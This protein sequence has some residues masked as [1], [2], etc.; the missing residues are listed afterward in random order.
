MKPDNADQPKE[1][2]LNE[3][4][5]DSVVD[6]NVATHSKGS[7]LGKLLSSGKLSDKVEIEEI[8]YDDTAEKD[9][10]SDITVIEKVIK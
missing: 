5:N 1:P 2:E 6:E 7:L 10:L 3:V 9:E 8:Q 4:D